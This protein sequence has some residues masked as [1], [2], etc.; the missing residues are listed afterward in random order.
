M[1]L[2]KH[3]HKSL[4]PQT[5]SASRIGHSSAAGYEPSVQIL[6][7]LIV[8][9]GM[10]SS[11]VCEVFSSKCWSW[12]RDGRHELEVYVTFPELPSAS[13]YLV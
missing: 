13:S 10:W 9:L 11:G 1:A 5:P 12:K 4:L 2:Q 8:R 7:L 6:V 3:V